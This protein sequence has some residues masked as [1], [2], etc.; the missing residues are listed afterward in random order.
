MEG[1]PRRGARGSTTESKW[2]RQ[3]AARQPPK[4]PPGAHFL[5][6]LLTS[7]PKGNPGLR[8]LPL[9]MAPKTKPNPGG[10][11]VHCKDSPIR[12]AGPALGK[13]RQAR[14]A[15]SLHSETESDNLLVGIKISCLTQHE[16]AASW[17][18]WKPR[19]GLLQT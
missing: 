19:V 17:F 12:T 8:L 13:H 1:S 4:V 14:K 6:G 11:G 5:P 18:P 3:G 2:G 16:P 9:N 7:L 10:R 15:M